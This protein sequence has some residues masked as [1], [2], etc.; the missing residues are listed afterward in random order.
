MIELAAVVRDLRKELNQA[1]DQ[2]PDNGLR[3]EAGPIEVELSVGIEQ[4]DGVKGKV[5]FYV[6]ELGGEMSDKSITTQKI[7]FTLTPT[8]DVNG[9][10]TTPW[11]AGKP[12]PGEE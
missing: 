6:F 7:K 12:E 2:A 5:N 3:F 10:R 1:I 4:T 8:V 11:V 9:Q